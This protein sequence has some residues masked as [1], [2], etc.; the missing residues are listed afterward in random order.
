VTYFADL[1]PYT[2]FDGEGPDVLNVGWLEPDH[3]YPRGE[4]PA[5][6]LSRLEEL[7]EERV[8]QTRGYH[9]CGF[10]MRDVQ[11]VAGEGGWFA[12]VAH[13]S[14]ELRVPGDGVTYAAP[15]LV[16][17][18]IEEHGYLPPAEFCAA[19]LNG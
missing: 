12:A 16:L 5:G 3:P 1:T 17:H 6:L 13:E 19:V 15:L 14:A 2:Y 18:Y 11:A 10:C 9:H 8:R 4:A 7:A